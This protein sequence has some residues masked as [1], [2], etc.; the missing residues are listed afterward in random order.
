MALSTLVVD[1]IL[2]AGGFESD[3]GRA[4]KTAQKRMREIEKAAKQAGKVMGVALVAGATAAAVALKSAIDRADE[5]SKAAQKIGVSTES[6]SQ[7]SYAAKLADVELGQLQAGLVR[8]TKAQSDAA[9]GT[10]K[11]AGLFRALGVEFKNSDG[12]L[13][14]VDQVFRDLSE[15]LSKVPD[16]ADKTAAAY[17]LLGRAGANLIPLLNGG[18]DGLDEMTKRAEALGVVI[19]TE[20][21]KR[22]EEFNDRLTDLNLMI[23]GLATSVAAELLPTIISL[24][25]EF[26][27]TIRDGGG[28]KNTAFEI[29]TGLRFV[30]DVALAAK[31]SVVFLTNALIYGA[32]K[33]G[34][35]FAR[36]QALNPLLN[37]AGASDLADKFARQADAARSGMDESASSA[38][39]R[40]DFKFDPS[41]PGSAGKAG[42]LTGDQAIIEALRKQ[43][44]AQKEAAK[45][46]TEGKAAATKAAREQEKAERALEQAMA[47][48]KRERDDFSRGV[49]DMVAELGGPLAQAT[50]AHSRQIKELQEL[51]DRGV[52]SVDEATKAQMAYDEALKRTTETIREQ[53]TPNE[54]YLEYLRQ[55]LEFIRATNEERQE[56]IA[57]RGLDKDATEAQKQAAIDLVKAIDAEGAALSKQIEFMDAFRS[58]FADN[59]ADVLTGATSIKDAF[60][61]MADAVIQQIARMIAQQW[62]EQLFGQMGSSGG[63]SSGNFI[64]SLFGSLFGG[65][66]A[67]GGPVDPSKSYVVGEHGA[68][69]FVPKTAG[70][71]VPAGGGVTQNIYV[72]GRVDS[73]TALQIAEESARRQRMSA[74]NA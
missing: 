72:Q 61:N 2:K 35:M 6:L 45:A 8:L 9:T 60:K 53:Q 34:E 14:N 52:I 11:T 63:G 1:L 46:A 24:T 36:L 55:E 57:L 56:L 20:T 29:A 4:S 71:I 66:R 67:H 62:T 40:F 28:V 47:A 54:E 74:R 10:E 37:L 13:R 27:R 49:E 59:V 68:E 39:G 58:S 31:D 73:R 3:M 17:E 48:V 51:L 41:T 65:G 33:A 42:R 15:A 7:L 21:G 18:A 30:G 43:I 19:D 16:G 70:A 44:E 26:A 5:L 25:D 38:T 32:N 12:T 22:A 50:L 69:W 23:Q 64:A